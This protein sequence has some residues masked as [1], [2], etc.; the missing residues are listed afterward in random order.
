M[1]T[2]KQQ[3]VKPEDR[4]AQIPVHTLVI[5]LCFFICRRAFYRK[6]GSPRRCSNCGST[7]FA[8]DVVVAIDYGTPCEEYIL[9]SDCGSTCAFWAYGSFDPKYRKYGAV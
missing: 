4:A 8:T 2:E 6:D 5:R 3:E 1:G 9:C 7:S